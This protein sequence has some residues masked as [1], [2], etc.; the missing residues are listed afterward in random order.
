[1]NFTQNITVIQSRD[2][3]LTLTRKGEKSLTIK[4]ILIN[5]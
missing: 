4:Y 1:M 3:D 5:W 2:N